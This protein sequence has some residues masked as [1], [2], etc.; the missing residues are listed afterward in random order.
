LDLLK[1]AVRDRVP[2]WM[3]YVNAEGTPSQRIV[4]PVSLSG[5]FLQGF[6]HKR[7]E[8]RTFAVHRITDVALVGETG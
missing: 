8:M 4:E 2:V 1:R 6:D 3:G 7:E 5:G